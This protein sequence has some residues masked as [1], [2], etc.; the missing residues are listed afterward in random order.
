MNN[1]DKT[2]YWNKWDRFQRRYEKIF[3]GKFKRALKEQTEQ[4]IIYRVIN[5]EPIYNVLVDIYKTVGVQWAHKVSLTLPRQKGRLPMGFTERIVE[6]M[7][8]YYGLDLYDD[9]EVIT[10]TT[11]EYIG[12][13]L[14]AAAEKG[15]SFDEIVRQ[16]RLPDLN[17]RRA[18][19]IARTETVTA[20]NGAAK[21][22][23]KETGLPM[24]KTW[25][26]VRDKRTRRDHVL[27]DNTM[28]DIDVPFIVGG[29]EMQQPGVRKQ[30][31]GLPVP[32]KEYINCRCT[33]AFTVKD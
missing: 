8:Q 9:A 33:A 10:G 30:D 4:Y 1:E 5:A 2:D 23:A 16:L 29:Y 19:V 20:A 27:A 3:I 7:R 18:R 6:L 17:D 11:R 22:Y 14:S 28:V 13:V 25:I 15:W 26:A 21:V 24:N 32:P 31:N 12:D